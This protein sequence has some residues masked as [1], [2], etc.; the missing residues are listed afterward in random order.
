MKANKTDSRTQ[1][2]IAVSLIDAI[3]AICKQLGPLMHKHTPAIKEAMKDVRFIIREEELESVF[4]EPSKEEMK[5]RE[6]ISKAVEKL[7]GSKI[8]IKL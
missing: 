7:K 4:Y 6:Y 5:N 2:G 3:G 8:R 1:E